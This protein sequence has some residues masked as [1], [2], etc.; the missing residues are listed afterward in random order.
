[1]SGEIKKQA[2]AKLKNT[3]D[4]KKNSEAKRYMDMVAV[5]DKVEGYVSLNIGTG[6]IMSMIMAELL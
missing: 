1:M 3:S 6:H 2:A 4:C 5:F